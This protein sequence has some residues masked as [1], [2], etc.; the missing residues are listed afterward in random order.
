MNSLT[1]N[2]RGYLGLSLDCYQ[3]RKPLF[4]P[5]RQKLAKT[6]LAVDAA[7][8]VVTGE[9]YFL[10]EAVKRGKVLLVSTDESANSTKTKVA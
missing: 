6:L 10:G 3:K 4:W 2:R 5:V 7:Y 8:S 1:W 9:S